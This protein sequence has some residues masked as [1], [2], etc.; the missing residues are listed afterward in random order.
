MRMLG[1]RADAEDAVQETFLRAH[2]A[3]GRYRER[4]LFR[5]WLF[6]ILVNRCRS[7]GLRRSREAARIIHDEIEMLRAHA[8]DVSEAEQDLGAVMEAVGSLDSLLR[9]AFLLKYVEEMDYEEMSAV[10]GV[11]VSALKMRVKRACDALR[12][13]LREMFDD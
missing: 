12:P 2:R 10:T 3:L 9:E 5:A 8:R 1:N 4:E 6:R 11:G 13:R 7:I